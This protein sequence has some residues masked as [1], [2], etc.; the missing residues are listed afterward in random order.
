M[1]DQTTPNTTSAA[2]QLANNL[3]GIDAR[4][5]WANDKLT[6][7]ANELE[8]LDALA[9]SAPVAPAPQPAVPDGFVLVP[10]KP[11]DA[12]LCAGFGYWLNVLES[13]KQRDTAAKEWA[14]MLAAAPE[15]APVAPAPQPAMSNVVNAYCKAWGASFLADNPFHKVSMQ[16][17]DKKHILAGLS[18]A[19][20]A[21]LQQGEYLPLP[22][23]PHRLGDIDLWP[24]SA[25]HQAIDAHRAAWEQEDS[26]LLTIAYMGGVSAAKRDAARGAA[27]ASPAEPAG[28]KAN[29]LDGAITAAV[30]CINT[31]I[32]RLQKGNTDGALEVAHKVKQAIVQALAFLDAPPAQSAQD[33]DPLQGAA[34][35]LVNSHASANAAELGGRLCV[36]YNRAERLFDAARAQQKGGEPA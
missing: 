22:P 27:Q 25:V 8:R 16:K 36:G 23:A 28:P 24:E 30:L 33:A 3:R 17:E 1:I 15:A 4:S 18:A 2:V 6:K 35:W 7:A 9:A 32:R 13:P 5:S 31:V 11:T 19:L 26:N 29:D 14:A 34:N 12:M 20:A 10:A 21:P